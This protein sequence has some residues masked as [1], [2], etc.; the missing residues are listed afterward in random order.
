MFPQWFETFKGRIS[1]Q[2]YNQ[3]MQI[4][5]RNRY[6][7]V[8]VAKAACST[9]ISR[10]RKVV[11]G[12]LPLPKEVHVPFHASPFV[13]PFQLPDEMMKDVMGGQGFF[14]F[15]FVRE[16]TERIV[17]AY[18]DKLTRETPQKEKFYSRFL[19]GRSLEE[20][21]SFDEFISVLSGIDNFSKYD[22]HW[23]PQS[24]LMLL[25]DQRYDFIG[26]FDRFESD[27]Q[28]LM[29]TLGLPDEDRSSITWHA[30]SAH[31][32][33]AEVMTEEARKKI[34][35]IYARDFELFESL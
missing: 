20:Q 14:R 32:K 7:Y 27:W 4:D 12:G 2:E 21:I 9:I 31:E 17:S 35:E 24:E 18:L 15:T 5:L 16:P 11:A 19:D 6:L 26:R 8:E 3:N 30:T 33:M 1:W 23:R 25:P 28:D 22:K 13:K 10:L 34:N 29:K